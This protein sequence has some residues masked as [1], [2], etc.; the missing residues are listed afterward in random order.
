MTLKLRRLLKKSKWLFLLPTIF[1][2]AGCKAIVGTAIVGTTV[3][4]V[5]GY[6]VYKGGEAVVTTAGDAGAAVGKS[7][8]MS[9]GTF[10]VKSTESVAVL[11][12]AASKSFQAAGFHSVTGQKDALS[13]QVQAMT[14]ENETVLATFEMLDGGETQVRIQVGDGNLKQSEYLYDD[15]LAKIGGAS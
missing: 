2:V 9:S 11:Y 7:V 6:G 13:G 5:A 12:Y 15:M 3:V 14:R 4:G 1:T 8:T 10:K